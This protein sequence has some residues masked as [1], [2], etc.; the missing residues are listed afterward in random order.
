[1]TNQ[2]W[3]QAI[4][5]VIDANTALRTLM[6]RS[7]NLVVEKW[8]IGVGNTLPMIAF[9]ILVYQRVADQVEVQFNAVSQH[10][11][12][13]RAD[14]LAMIEGVKAALT[15][16]AFL[17]AGYADVVPVNAGFDPPAE[18]VPDLRGVFPV[19]AD[20]PLRQ[21]ADWQVSL[22]HDS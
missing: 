2:Q 7:S 16:T 4:V 22:R 18:E 3:R 20:N 6:G 12:D 10:A 15:Y 13:P 14:A 8:A 17:T 21:Q 1:M 9:D 11:A 19:T 5:A